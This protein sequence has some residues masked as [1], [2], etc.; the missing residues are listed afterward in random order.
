MG[1]PFSSIVLADG[2]EETEDVKGLPKVLH[3]C[4]H[5]EN[6]KVRAD[7]WGVLSLLTFDGKTISGRFYGQ[8]RTANRNQR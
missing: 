3:A 7:L 2:A 5:W 8:N 4:H 1:T 6:E